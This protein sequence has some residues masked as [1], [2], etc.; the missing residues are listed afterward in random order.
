LAGLLGQ[1]AAFARGQSLTGPIAATQHMDHMN[2]ADCAGM[3]MES[4]SHDGKSIPCK[5][6]TPDCMSQMG[7]VS[8]VLLNE[9]TVPLALAPFVSMRPFESSTSRLIGRSYAPEPN[10]PSL[11]N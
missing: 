8:P 4:P 2:G 7:C 10:P 3:L 9:G 5:G 6:M 1:E 11:L